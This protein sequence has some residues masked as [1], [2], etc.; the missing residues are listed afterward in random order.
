MP[1][2]FIISSIGIVEMTHGP[3]MAGMEVFDSYPKHVEILRPTCILFSFACPQEVER[4][5][6]IQPL[7]IGKL[8]CHIFAC[9]RFIYNWWICLPLL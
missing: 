6:T 1:K 8:A 5:S 4:K 7:T 3:L 2:G 9:L